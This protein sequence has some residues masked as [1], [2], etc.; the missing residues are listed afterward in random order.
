MKN[1][2][3]TLT[4]L[5]LGAYPFIQG[6][7]DAYNHG[8]FKDKNTPIEILFGAAII[9]GGLVSKDHNVTGKVLIPI[10]ICL[11]ALGANAQTSS[12]TS[13]IQFTGPSLFYCTNINHNPT[14]ALIAAVGIQYRH[15]SNAADWGVAG[16]FGQGGST[17]PGTISG[18][19]AFGATVSVK[20]IGNVSLPMRV[21]FGYFYNIQTRN[22][23][24]AYGGGLPLGL[25]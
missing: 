7:Y 10:L 20:R 14:G 17:A 6:L 11:G 9:I 23:M 1:W 5:F 15:V 2:R 3:T 24:Y 8:F 22:S 21:I 18:V 19:T 12:D 25:Q 16:Q 13:G 4:G